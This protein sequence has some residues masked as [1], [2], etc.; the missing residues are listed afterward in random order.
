MRKIKRIGVLSLGKIL[1]IIYALFGFIG[2]AILSLVAITGISMSNG[3]A[4]LGIAFG[5]GAIIILPIIYGVLG[6]ISGILCGAIYNLAALWMGGIE[7]E[8][9]TISTYSSAAPAPTNT[10]A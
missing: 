7:I 6:F 3:G 9:E 10:T 5:I 4:G 8:V 2:G 1:G